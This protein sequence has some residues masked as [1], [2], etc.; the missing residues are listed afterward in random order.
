LD[1]VIRV[2]LTGAF[3]GIRAVLPHMRK[4]GGG[5]IVNIA[6]IAGQRI[7]F[8]GTANYTASK[9]GLLG[10]TRHVAYELAPEGIR[11]NAVCPGATAT[12]FG[13]A[14]PTEET[15]AARARKIPSGRLCEPEDIADPILFLASHAARMITGAALTVDGGV[16]IKNDTPYE[17]YLRRE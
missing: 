2:N 13:D 15:R 10:L 16:L 5:T 7:S 11:L 6:S 12:G 4:R 9:A 3:N 8:G 17:E 14:I 1:R